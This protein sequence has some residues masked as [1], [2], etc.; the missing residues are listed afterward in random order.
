M[1][2]ESG[3]ARLVEREVCRV[4]EADRTFRL[5]RARGQCQWESLS[6]AKTAD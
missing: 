4:E 6:K 5:F 1:I 2:A 3:I